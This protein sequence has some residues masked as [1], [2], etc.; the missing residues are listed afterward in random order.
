M[1]RE[2]A[3]ERVSSGKGECIGIIRPNSRQIHAAEGAE[4]SI[5][6]F[7]SIASTVT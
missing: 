7:R 1:G 3:G 2:G 5:G 6:R 4:Q